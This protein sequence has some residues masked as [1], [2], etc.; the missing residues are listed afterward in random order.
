MTTLTVNQNYSFTGG[1]RSGKLTIYDGSQP[2]RPGVAI[3][4]PVILAEWQ[5][6]YNAADCFPDVQAVLGEFYRLGQP[7][8]AA[9]IGVAFTTE[10]VSELRATFK[11]LVYAAKVIHNPDGSITVLPSK[12]R[13]QVE[14]AAQ[15]AAILRQRGCEVG[16]VCL[17]EY[18][19]LWRFQA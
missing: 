10:D 3:T 11:R 18:R 2:D 9:A 15:I 8:K 16:T 6:A 5:K 4:D 7:L 17:S 14:T 13:W 12:F 19:H 1:T